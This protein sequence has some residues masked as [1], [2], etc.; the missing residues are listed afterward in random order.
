[1]WLPRKWR[2]PNV[3]AI[4]FFRGGLNGKARDFNWHN[5]IGIWCA[6]PLVVVVAT[7]VAMSYPW[8]NNALYRITGNQ[9]PPV[10]QGLP[11]GGQRPG[12]NERESGVRQA[13]AR[14]LESTFD[15]LAIPLEQAKT[16]DPTWVQI[17]MRLPSKEDPSSVQFTIVN[18][19]EGRPDH[20][21]QLVLKRDSGEVIRWEPFAKNNAGRRLR[22]WFRFL[23]TGEAGGVT[24]QAIA[25]LASAGAVLLMY[26]GTALAIQRLIAWNR[27]RKGSYSVQEPALS[28]K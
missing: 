17:T 14:G 26:T 20:R 4:L 18:G 19:I 6:I 25:A 12:A 16:Q 24:G 5:V 10:Q 2:W 9:P 21:S 22:I 11:E 8:A 27:R 28:S 3:R 23:H 1:L 7:A 15:G 13:A